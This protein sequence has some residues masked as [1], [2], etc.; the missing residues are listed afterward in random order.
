MLAIGAST[1]VQYHTFRVLNL[2]LSHG[3]QYISTFPLSLQHIQPSLTQNSYEAYYDLWLGGQ[4]TFK[5]IA[6]HKEYGP[7]IRISPW[8][9]HI[10]DPDFYE[11]VYASSGSGHRRDK[12][13]WF[14]KSFGLDNS[15]FATPGHDL[16]RLRR[17][18]L[19]PYFSMASVRRLQPLLQERVNKLLERFEGFRD[20]GEVLNTSWAYAAF[21]NGKL[22]R[23]LL[24]KE[25]AYS[26][27]RCCNDLLL[28]AMR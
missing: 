17:S 2:L 28:R 21:T 16:H 3:C 7:I 18:A 8:E 22:C 20:T 10:A 6:L 19:A 15:V 25:L 23:N 14:T 9:I 11:V 5:I 27:N 26:E 24:K 1:S 12:Y 4:Y 13:E